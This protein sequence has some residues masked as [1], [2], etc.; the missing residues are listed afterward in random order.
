MEMQRVFL[1]QRADIWAFRYE[2]YLCPLSFPVWNIQYLYP[3]VQDLS[4]GTVASRGKDLSQ[5]RNLASAGVHN[6]EEIGLEYEWRLWTN[7]L[8]P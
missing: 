6:Y 3:W 8:S 5:T 4:A 1:N 7:H 2:S